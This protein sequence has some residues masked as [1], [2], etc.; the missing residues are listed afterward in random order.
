MTPKDGGRRGS[1]PDPGHDPGRAIG[2]P[3]RRLSALPSVQARVLAFAAIVVAGLC[4]ALS[5]YGFV[6]VQCHGTCTT[7]KGLGALWWK[8]RQLIRADLWL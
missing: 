6:G 8:G 4:G 7:P 5:G 3:D 1:Q 2:R